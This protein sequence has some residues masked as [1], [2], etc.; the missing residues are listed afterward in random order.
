MMFLT[1]VDKNSL[2]NSLAHLTEQVRYL[3]YF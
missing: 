1:A 3:P 2:L